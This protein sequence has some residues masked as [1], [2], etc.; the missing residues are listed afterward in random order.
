MLQFMNNVILE[1]GISYGIHIHRVF[2]KVIDRKF[3]R[4]GSITI[5]TLVVH[6]YTGAVTCRFNQRSY[7]LIGMGRNNDFK[8]PWK[9]SHGNTI[10]P[11]FS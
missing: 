6:R 2:R 9:F 11:F 8:M 10:Y 3:H 1:S 4:V 5:L 7:I